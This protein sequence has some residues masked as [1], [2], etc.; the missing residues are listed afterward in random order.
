LVQ[1]REIALQPIDINGIV[2]EVLRLTTG[3][4]LR[5]QVSVRNELASALPRVLA[6][7]IHLQ[8]LILNLVVNAMDAMKDTP[9]ADRVLSICTRRDGDDA[10]EV[11]I[12]DQGHG[13]APNKLSGVFDS[14]FTTKSDGMGLGLSIARSIVRSHGG[15][16]R[17][18]NRPEGGA[19]FHFTLKVHDTVR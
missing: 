15:T 10:V 4:V 2:E 18:E 16:I 19:A 5:C 1:K 6:D 9:V 14:F 11:V 17:A 12:A 3:D 13:I 8:Q 7:R